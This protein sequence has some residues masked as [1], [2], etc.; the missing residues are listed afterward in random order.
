MPCQATSKVAALPC[1]DA[2]QGKQQKQTSQ[3]TDGSGLPEKVPH[4]QQ[5]DAGHQDDEGQGRLAAVQ[6]A[7]G[8]VGR[9]AGLAGHELG[10][11]GMPRHERAYGLQHL[12][13]NLEGQRLVQRQCLAEIRLAPQAAQAQARQCRE[14]QQPGGAVPVRFDGR[15]E[16]Q[17]AD[18]Q[19]AEHATQQQGEVRRHQRLAARGV[20]GRGCH[21]SCLP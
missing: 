18:E 1:L 13:D 3:R 10:L 16:D 12:G 15:F 5:R 17:P 11:E 8:Q 4:Q 7:T 6:P 19:Q 20:L 2:A 21:D 9:Q 14:Q